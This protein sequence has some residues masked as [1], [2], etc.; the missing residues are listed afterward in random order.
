MP[1]ILERQLCNLTSRFITHEFHHVLPQK[2]L[3]QRTL[4]SSSGTAIIYCENIWR[5]ILNSNAILLLIFPPPPPGD[6]M[7]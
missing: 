2:T 7:K 4:A 3:S 6:L 5:E 1:E